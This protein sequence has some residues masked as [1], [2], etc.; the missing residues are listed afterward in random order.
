MKK[1]IKKN[2]KLK[3]MMKMIISLNIIAKSLMK[4]VNPYP[5]RNQKM[6]LKLII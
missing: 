6:I 1:K 4:V 2:Q 3:I 5:Q